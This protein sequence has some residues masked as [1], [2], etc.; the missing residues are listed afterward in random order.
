MKK[1]QDLYGLFTEE[2]LEMYSS[3]Q[4]IINS[5]PKL[6]QIASLPDLKNALAK[7][8]DETKKH[9]KRIELIFAELKIKPSQ[10]ICEVMQGLIKEAEELTSAANPSAT[11]DAAIITAAQKVEHYEISTYGSLYSFAKHLDLSDGVLDLLSETLDEEKDA[12]DKLTDIADGTFFAT[13]VNT[14]AAKGY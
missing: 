1:N 11:R 2:L 6:I 12:N 9:L 14:K 10:K 5:L 3:E 4:Q 13:G 8:L 7:H